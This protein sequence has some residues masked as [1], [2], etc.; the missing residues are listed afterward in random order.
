MSPAPS[1]GAPAG[2]ASR[3]ARRRV[4]YISG[5]DPR[6]PR[7]YHQMWQAEA[8]KQATVDG[9][10]YEV[11]AATD[12]GPLA[13]R[14]TVR[15]HH[16]GQDTESR[17]VFLR[18]EDLMRELWPASRLA[19]IANMPRMYWLYLRSGL[20]ART[21]SVAR[22]FFWAY[23]FMPLIYVVLSLLIVAGTGWA[24]NTL[25]AWLQAPD[26]L[27]IGCSIAAAAALLWALLENGDRTRLFWL[28]GAHVFMVRWARDGPDPFAQRWR[29]FAALIEADLQ[30][31][32][33]DSAPDEVLIVGHCG[34]APAAVAVAQCWLA[35]QP[36]GSQPTTRVKLLTL[37]QAIPLLSVIPQASWFRDQLRQVGESQMP[38][39]DYT[40]PADPLCYR[41][42]DPFTICGLPSPDRPGFRVK[43]S[44]FD[45]MFPPAEYAKLRRDIFSVHFQYLKATQLPV[46]NDY[47]RLTCGPQPLNFG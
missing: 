36:A 31:D 29:D 16:D 5:V 28:A 41:L 13:T 11:G 45:R 27:G 20:L 18:W 47:F 23:F 34:G 3:V 26:W 40:A 1:T 6:G 22:P 15:S 38:W 10:R 21:W 44:R 17:H 42:T 8:Q 2:E 19:V 14:W 4:Y 24:V 7:F 37:G 39:L 43:S 35:L 9:R 32:T 46:E 25:M 12:D 30:R 33:A